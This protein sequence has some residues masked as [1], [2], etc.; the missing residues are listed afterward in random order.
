MFNLHMM[1][2]DGTEIARWHGTFPRSTCKA[3]WSAP[4]KWHKKSGPSSAG[5]VWGTIKIYRKEAPVM[6]SVAFSQTA[7]MTLRPRH[8]AVWENSANHIKSALAVYVQ[9]D[10]T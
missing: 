8:C 10:M 5:H 4:L 1:G 9:Y 7:Q 3:K 2:I 6:G